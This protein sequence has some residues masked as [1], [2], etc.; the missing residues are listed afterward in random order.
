MLNELDI[1]KVKGKKGC[2]ILINLTKKDIVLN[3]LRTFKIGLNLFG[4]LKYG[5]D[6]TNFNS[7]ETLLPFPDVKD[8][9]VIGKE[10]D[11]T[12]KELMELLY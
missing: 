7:Y 12:V 9:K 8:I 3:N 6:A 10:S 1:V 11:Y 5:I 4:G 2:Y